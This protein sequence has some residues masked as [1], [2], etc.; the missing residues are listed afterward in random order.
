MTA[1]I[2]FCILSVLLTAGKLLRL[3]IP[4]LQKLYLP[5]SV[6]GGLAG[7]VVITIFKD[8]IPHEWISG[9]KQLPGFLI[10]VVFASLFLGK[11]TPAFKKIWTLAMPQLCMGQLLAWG[12]YVLGLGLCGFLLMPCFGVPAAFGNLLEIGF[13][14]GHGTVGGLTST[15][16]T[17]KWSDGIALGYTMATAGMVLGIVVGMVLVNWALRKGVIRNVQ[18]FH[19]RERHEQRG[20]YRLL[21]R[22]DA[23]KQTVFCDSIDSLAWHI[24][25]IGLAILLGFLMLKGFQLLEIELFPKSE[26]KRIFSGFPLFPLCMIGG[27]IL[28]KGM[29]KVKAHALIDHGQMQRLAGAALDFLVVSAVATIQIS[30]VAANWQSLLVL[31]AAGTLWS[32]ILVVYLAPRLFKEAWFERAIAEFGQSLGVT[33][34]G[35]LLLRTVDPENKTVAAESF[36]YKQL[37]HEPFMGGGLWTALA[38]TLVFNIGWFKLFLI[39]CGALIFWCIPTL[40]FVLKNRK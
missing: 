39:S 27:L 28:Q 1:I 33:A 13:Q 4:I 32:V 20:I 40:V 9:M 34:T 6:V 12:Q 3:N 2:I 14:G 25:L 22:P 36:G 29:E 16:E 10:N 7:L 15:F 8:R 30:V 37:L 31:I 26:G 11:V 38:L 19:N 17:F 5:S 35:L 23:G 18:T 24:A 21:K